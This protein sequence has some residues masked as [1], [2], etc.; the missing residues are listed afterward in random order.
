[1]LKNIFQFL[2]SKTFLKHLAIYIVVLVVVI[3]CVNTWLKSTTNHGESIQVP[4]FSKLK[5]AELDNFIA[6]K[7]VKY[8]VIDSIYDPKLPKG[9]VVKQEPEANAQVKENRTIYLYV[10]SILPPSVEMPKLVDRSLRQASAMI[11]SYGLKIGKI[12]YKADQCANCVLEQ[13]VKGKKIEPGTLIEKGTKVDLIVGKGLG[14]EEVGVPC[15]LGLT[16]KEAIERLLENSLAV[17][18]V[19]FDVAKDSLQSKVYKQIPACGK[20]T[21]VNMGATIDI[22]LT[23]DKNKIPAVTT[24]DNKENEYDQ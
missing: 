23:S 12:D 2:K 3:F 7:Q 10:T 15:L 18:A 11:A 22:F 20:E 1:M 6:D 4:D 14:D 19:S 24:S 21:T 16:R 5:L 9:I 13:F 8:E 17:G